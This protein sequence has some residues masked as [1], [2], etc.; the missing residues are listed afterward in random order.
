MNLSGVARLVKKQFIEEKKMK[1]D[2]MNHLPVTF[3][4]G[5]IRF[6]HY[7]CD[8]LVTAEGSLL[9]QGMVSGN[10]SLPMTGHDVLQCLIKLL[11]K[12]V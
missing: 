6:L 2:W 3:K 7:Q 9:V 10:A 8:Q 11:P 4:T 5:P 12:P 1:G